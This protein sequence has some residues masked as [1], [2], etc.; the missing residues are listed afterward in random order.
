MKDERR[1][2][3]YQ[4]S[5]LSRLT[6]YSTMLLLGLRLEPMLGA[7]VVSVGTFITLTIG[8]CR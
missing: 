4:V 8:L 1:E 3:L 2:V 5:G 6:R 7:L